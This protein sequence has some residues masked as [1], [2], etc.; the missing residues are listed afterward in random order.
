MNSFLFLFFFKK[1]PDLTDINNDV[2]R[3]WKCIEQHNLL[4]GGRLTNVISNLISCC[5][6]G[7][8]VSTERLS[9]IE[10]ENNG[11][12]PWYNPIIILTLKFE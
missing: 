11:C 1:N 9:I 12:V 4:A 7:L 8:S 6:S 3:R 2:R 5:Q 10:P